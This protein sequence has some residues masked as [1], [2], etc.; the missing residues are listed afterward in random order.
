MQRCLFPHLSFN[1][2][3]FFFFCL[4][5]LFE[6]TSQKRGSRE[7]RVEKVTFVCTLTEQ[8]LYSDIFIFSLYEVLSDGHYLLAVMRK[9]KL[10]ACMCVF[11]S[12]YRVLLMSKVGEVRT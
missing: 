6:I 9:L 3:L 12:A 11:M 1:C 10:C 8:L 7:R 2:G 4:R 5:F